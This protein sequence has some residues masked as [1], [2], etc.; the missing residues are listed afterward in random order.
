MVLHVQII[1]VFSLARHEVCITAQTVCL[2]P[3]NK[4]SQQDACAVRCSLPSRSSSGWE[5]LHMT[6]TFVLDGVVTYM[7]YWT[8]IMSTAYKAW[9]ENNN[10]WF[11]LSNFHCSDF[12]GLDVTWFRVIISTTRQWVP[13]QAVIE[14]TF[15]KYA[16][17]RANNMNTSMGASRLTGNWTF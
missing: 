4:S 10:F 15:E 9:R 14:Y 13:D 5:Q 1:I 12:T 11:Y 7:L 16:A 17:S 2:F 3:S 8:S 6:C